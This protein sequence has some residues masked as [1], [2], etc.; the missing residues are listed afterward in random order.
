MF[1]FLWKGAGLVILRFFF[2]YMRSRF[3]ESISYELVAKDRLAIGDALKRVSLGYFSEKQH[4]NDPN[5]ITTG[6][7]LLENMGIPHD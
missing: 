2:D 6:L 1:F 4:R 5:S 7:N 3:Q